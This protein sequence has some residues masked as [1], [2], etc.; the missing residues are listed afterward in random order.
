MPMKLR[1]LFKFI[2]ESRSNVEKSIVSTP[3][4]SKIVKDTGPS[5]KYISSPEFVSG[6]NQ[7]SVF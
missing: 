1:I 2:S 5:I 6:L 4:V 3:P 7:V